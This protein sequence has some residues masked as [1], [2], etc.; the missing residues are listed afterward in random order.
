[1]LAGCAVAL[2]SRKGDSGTIAAAVGGSAALSSAVLVGL[3]SALDILAAIVLGA[4]FAFA[5][6]VAVNR[7]ARKAVALAALVVIL[8][9]F[10][11]SVGLLPGPNAEPIAGFK[12]ST[13]APEPMPEQYAF[14][15][16]IYLRTFHLVSQGQPYYQA[17]Q[18]SIIE[19]SRI[20]KAPISAFNY[21]PPLLFYLWGLFPGDGG[22]PVWNGLIFVALLSAVAGFALVHRL[23]NSGAALVAP[24]LLLSYFV[25]PAVTAWGPFS[26]FWAGA[27]LVLV[28]AAVL[29]DRWNLA[30]VFFTFAVAMHFLALALAP[31]LL[32]GWLFGRGWREERLAIVIGILGPVLVV[33]SHFALAPVEGGAA[34]GL[35]MWMNGGWVRLTDA[36]T[37][38]TDFVWAGKTL[39]VWTPLLALASALSAG[40]LHRKVFVGA[41]AFS[42]A[43]FLVSV[44]AG[45]WG[46]YWGAVF[47]PFMLAL[48]P[49]VLGLLAGPEDV[50]CRP[51]A[52]SRPRPSVVKF[53]LPAYN[54]EASIKELVERIGEV[55]SAENQRYSV[56]VVDDGSAD[57]TAK[58]ASSLVPAYPITVVS[59][60]KNLGL[61]CTIRKGLKAAS[62]H[63]HPNEV[64]VTMDADL[65][66][67]PTY[68]P[69]MIER[70][71]AGADV[72]IASRF[73]HGSRVVGLSPLRHVTTLGA[74]LTMDLFLHTDGVRDYSCGY[75]LYAAPVLRDAFKT[76]G[77]GLICQG[78][79]ACMV[80]ILGRMRQSACFA[81]VPFVLHYE[82]KRT[83]S[84]MNVTR[85]ALAYFKVIKDVYAEELFHAGNSGS[86]NG[87]SR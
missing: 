54:E 39:L 81:E 82:E 12:E 4:A 19:D 84:T 36:L 16:F 2:A 24:A 45:E 31:A 20:D 73:R 22:M 9:S 56:L 75:R 6:T 25:Y 1:L 80:E 58:V 60:K 30:A 43:L 70:Y 71:R 63:A 21:R 69:S 46:Y 42:A 10:L 68:V 65:T 52:E 51:G 67:D 53:V 77:D 79:F 86:A 78:G 40:P 61:G 38:S 48:A 7:G 59:N 26:E 3:S 83:A 50:S 41:S 85:T 57:A 18:T 17:M 13:I 76:H 55:M 27:F 74:R 28:V 5:T 47:Q 44:S 32:L 15:G 8:G 23:A 49:G 66:Q 64:I 35:A 72:V 62:V 87:G 14:D 11:W 34:T 37:F 33:G 29:R